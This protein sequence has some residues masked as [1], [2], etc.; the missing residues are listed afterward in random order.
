MKMK[1]E[2]DCT[3]EE[4][5]AFVGLPDVSG[6]NGR[7]VEEVGRRL[8]TAAFPTEDLFRT[9]LAFGGQAAENFLQMMKPPARKEGAGE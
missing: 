6:L 1:I 8:D 7:L 5:R 9:W 2:I 4:A 3:P